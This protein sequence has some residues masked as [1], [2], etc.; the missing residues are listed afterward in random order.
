MI[1]QL[2]NQLHHCGMKSSIFLL[3]LFLSIA[4][5]GQTQ[6]GITLYGYVQ[7]GTKGIAGKESD[8]K[9]VK[10]SP[11]KIYTY[12]MYLASNSRNRIYPAEIWIKGERLGV[13]YETVSQTPVTISKDDALP[14]SGQIVLVPKTTALVLHLTGSRDMPEKK[15]NRA[16]DIAANNE[17]VVVYKSGGNYHY[18]ALKKFS[19]L[20]G[21]VLQ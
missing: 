7:S 17:L 3:G 21:G 15:F 13:K 2:K 19:E 18:A 1:M 10:K 8:K 12:H 4:V 5:S 6:K 11:S 9:G 14:N 20:G 16:K